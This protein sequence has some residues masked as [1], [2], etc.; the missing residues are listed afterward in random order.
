MIEDKQNNIF[1]GY[2]S[3]E[4]GILKYHYDPK[5]FVFSLMRNGEMMMK[6]YPL[7]E[8][9][10]DFYVSDD[11]SDVL[12]AF[13]AE[14]EKNSN[15]FRDICIV[16]RDSDQKS[17]CRQYS[18]EYNGEG[19]ALT[20]SGDFEVK[21]IVVYAMCETEKMKEE[22]KKEEQQERDEDVKRRSE[23]KE[24]IERILYQLTRKEIDGTIFDSEVNKWNR[25][26]SEFR[27]IMNGKRNVCV[28][29]EDE[30]HNLFGGFIGNETQYMNDQTCFVFSIK[31]DGV[32]N[33]RK[34][35]KNQQGYSYN[36]CKNDFCVL[37]GFGLTNDYYYKDIYIYKKDYSCS[38][39]CL[40][41]A[42]DYGNQEFA[43]CGKINF[44]VKRIIVYQMK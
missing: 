9:C 42:F 29:V 15:Y 37:M 4:V 2:V 44:N 33:P 8:R 34:F 18:Y 23:E 28:V 14:D 7:K 36:I 24:E 3:K 31:K 30:R 39:C 1:G 5:S 43:L 12:F 27:E 22:R 32:F 17:Y 16:K 13:G 41:Y 35:K 20:G 11:L 26:D 25:N 38:G 10:Y 6:K 40:Q 19:N 21:Q